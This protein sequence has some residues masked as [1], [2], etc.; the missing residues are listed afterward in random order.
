MP[1]IKLIL[2]NY[3]LVSRQVAYIVPKWHAATSESKRLLSDYYHVNTT[4]S[5]VS[6]ISRYFLI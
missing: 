3:F 1:A 5:G 6:A 4:Y 2:I